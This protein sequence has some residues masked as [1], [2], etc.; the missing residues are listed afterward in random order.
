MSLRPQLVVQMLFDR[1]SYSVYLMMLPPVISLVVPAI[2][3]LVAAVIVALLVAT[4]CRPSPPAGHVLL[5][6]RMLRLC[7]PI[8]TVTPVLL[9]LLLLLLLPADTHIHTCSSTLLTRS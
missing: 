5:V 1:Q 3:P 6:C 2:T 4:G 8:P 9:L 7:G